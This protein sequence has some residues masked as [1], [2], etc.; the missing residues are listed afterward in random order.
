MGLFNFRKRKKVQV[1]EKPRTPEE[2]VQQAL[3]AQGIEA[4]TTE[5]AEIIKSLWN[6]IDFKPVLP[7]QLAYSKSAELEV[8]DSKYRLLFSMVLLGGAGQVPSNILSILMSC[9][10]YWASASELAKA[11]GN[12]EFVLQEGQKIAVCDYDNF[13]DHPIYALFPDLLNKTVLT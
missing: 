1:A 3:S 11:K 12:D 9:A 6:S 4:D 2:V 7:E 5:I 13:G 10:V 8:R